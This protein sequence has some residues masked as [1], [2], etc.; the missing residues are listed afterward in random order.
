MTAISQAPSSSLDRQ[1]PTAAEARDF[2]G[3]P[4]ARTTPGTGSSVCSTARLYDPPPRSGAGC[5]Y[6]RLIPRPRA[7]SSRSTSRQLLRTKV[8]EEAGYT[9]IVREILTAARRSNC[10]MAVGRLVHPRGLSHPNRGQP[11]TS[12]RCGTAS[13]GN[14]APGMVPSATITHSQAGS[15]TIRELAAFFSRSVRAGGDTRLTCAEPRRPAPR[16]ELTHPGTR[17][18]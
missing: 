7:D 1:I 11:E 14:P 9:C 8:I 4:R 13:P 2:P 6:P 5:F 17:R 15:G 3:R 12:R 18:S 16:R 10:D